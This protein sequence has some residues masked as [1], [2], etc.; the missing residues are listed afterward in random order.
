VAVVHAVVQRSGVATRSRSGVVMEWNGV[1]EL[2]RQW[3][4]V[5]QGGAALQC[6]SGAAMYRGVVPWHGG[7]M[8]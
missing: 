7:V 5:L 3:S 6:W 4:G 1:H 8:Q 2:V